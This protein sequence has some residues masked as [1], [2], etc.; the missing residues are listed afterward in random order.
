MRVKVD[1]SGSRH[2]ESGPLG[3]DKQLMGSQLGANDERSIMGCC[4]T[5]SGRQRL[6]DKEEVS[7]C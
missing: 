4:Q 7:W 5:N 2:T 3:G 6:Q 1:E